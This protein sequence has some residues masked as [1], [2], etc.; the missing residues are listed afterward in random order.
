MTL[1]VRPE[2]ETV[3]GLHLVSGMAGTITQALRAAAY[4]QLLSDFG[5]ET[6]PEAGLMLGSRGR[7]PARQSSVPPPGSEQFFGE[8][9]AHFEIQ[10]LIGHGGMGLVYRAWDRV[11]CRSVAIKVLPDE[12]LNG[13]PGQDQLLD[14]ARAQARLSSPN[15]VHV[16]YVGR[17]PHPERASSECPFFAM[18]LCSGG[19]LDDVLER[20]ERL[21]P[22]RAR[23]LL[24]GVAAG[25][26]D[27]LAA[28]M[29]HCD[30]KP[31]NLLLDENDRVRVADFGLS[32]TLGENGTVGSTS[33]GWCRGTP[34]YLAPERAKGEDYDHR[35]DMY[36]LGCTFYHL[37]TGRPPFEGKNVIRILHGHLTQ[38]A[39][40][41]TDLAPDVPKKLARI[42]ERLMEKD[43]SRR[44]ASY[45]ELLA[46]LQAAA[47]RPSLGE[48]VGP[49]AAAVAVDVT[50]TALATAAL[51][52]PGLLVGLAV[53][54][55]HAWL[56]R[57]SLAA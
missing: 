51:G 33:R 48:K 47:E 20:G 25:L 11:L 50:A 19:T 44:F 32:R 49:H 26:R 8:T 28:G 35:A 15:V 54:G 34:L 29:V 37:L 53:A 2:A 7:P 1:W 24:A 5:D 23:A 9:C 45:D 4:E 36:S 27:A 39:P 21:D 38:R 18:E 52:L 14:E 31:S 6:L 56:R 57:A 30:I 55:A 22:A 13:A 16:Y 41:L 3:R 42:L 17:A 40:A 12:C 10:S 43:P 46:A